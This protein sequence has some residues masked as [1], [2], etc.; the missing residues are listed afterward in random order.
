MLSFRNALT[1]GIVDAKALQYHLK[2]IVDEDAGE[3]KIWSTNSSVHFPK[4]P[5]GVPACSLFATSPPGE[6][7]RGREN[8]P[9]FVGI[10]LT[11]VRLVEQET[12]VLV[13]VNVPHIVGQYG[14]EEVRLEE[15][16]RGG[17]V[18]RAERV[19]ER[20]IGS[21]EIREW[22]LFVN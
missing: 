21:F 10:L 12:D 22:E 2:D 11:L 16:V 20:V 4:L 6:K 18:E 8:E 17:L 5:A 1:N 19:M 3:T 15:G 7:Q 9:E 14:V 13:A